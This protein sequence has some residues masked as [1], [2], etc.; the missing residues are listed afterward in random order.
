M[1]TQATIDV[2]KVTD[3]AATRAI[4]DVI[5]STITI[6]NYTLNFQE[7]LNG[8]TAFGDWTVL[9]GTVSL[10]QNAGGTQNGFVFENTGA[11]IGRPIPITFAGGAVVTRFDV[12]SFQSEYGMGTS[13]D[14]DFEIKIYEGTSEAGTLVGTFAA[15]ALTDTPVTTNDVYMTIER[16]DTDADNRVMLQMFTREL[17]EPTF[18]FSD[19]VPTT[20]AG[21]T[22]TWTVD[23]GNATPTSGT[24][25]INLTG[26]TTPNIGA[27]SNVVI[28]VMD[29]VTAA[30]VYEN[31]ASATGTELSASQ[32]FNATGQAVT[33]GAAATSLVE[34]TGANN[35]H[36]KQ[37]NLTGIGHNIPATESTRFSIY[38]TEALALAGGNGDVLEMGTIVGDGTDPQTIENGTA[39]DTSPLV[40][41]TQYWYK[42]RHFDDI[43]PT[44]NVIGESGVCTFT[45]RAADDENFIVCFDEGPNPASRT[46]TLAA[47]RFGEDD[48]P[49]PGNVSVYI[50]WEVSLSP[51]GPWTLANLL[52]L[53]GNPEANPSYSP[54]ATGGL[55]RTFG[56]LDHNTVY[57]SR[58][59]IG[60]DG[61]TGD[62]ETVNC[63]PLAITDDRP[64]PVCTSASN[65]TETTATVSATAD[66]TENGGFG[67]Y[68]NGDTVNLYTS[69]TA[70]GPW[71][72][73]GT[74][75]VNLDPE[76]AIEASV[77][78]NLTGLTPD[79]DYFYAFEI[80]E[81]VESGG[82]FWDSR[83]DGCATPFHTL[84]P[85]VGDPSVTKT[86]VAPDPVTNPA[87][88]VSTVVVTMA[89]FGGSVDVSDP[90]PAT[91]AGTTRSWTST[92]DAT[93]SAGAGTG[94]I[95]ETLVFA[96]AGTHTYTITDTVT[97]GGD[98]QNT[99]SIDGGPDVTGGDP[100]PVPDP[101]PPVGD[102]PTEEP[103]GNAKCKNSVSL[104]SQVNITQMCNTA[105][106]DPVPVLLVTVASS[107][108]DVIP[109]D[110]T[111]FPAEAGTDA[112]G[113]MGFMRSYYTD[114]NG[115]YLQPQ[116]TQVGIC[117]PTPQV[118][119][120]IAFAPLGCVT[121]AAGEV[122]G[123]VFTA[124]TAA[125]EDGG[126][127]TYRMISISTDGTVT[128][129]YTGEWSNCPTDQGIRATETAVV[130]CANGQTVIE[131]RT[132]YFDAD[133]G[134]FIA[135][136]KGWDDGTGVVLV[137]P[138][139]FAYGEC[140][141]AAIDDVEHTETVESGCVSGV[142]WT[143]VTTKTYT[144]GVL[145]DTTVVYRDQAGTDQAAQ[146][147]LWTL[148]AC[149]YIADDTVD[150][151][152]VTEICIENP[153][154]TFSNAYSR[155]V[156]RRTVSGLGVVSIVSST[157][158]SVDGVN[159]SVTVPTG[160][161]AV[162]VCPINASTRSTNQ[163]TEA[164][165]ADGVPYSRITS[166]VYNDG[167]LE[168]SNTV[169][170]DS[171]E[172]VSVVTPTNFTLGACPVDDAAI[173]EIEYTSSIPACVENPAGNFTQW[174][175][176]QRET[177]DWLNGGVTL[178]DVA[179]EWSSDGVT[180]TPTAPAGT[181]TMGQ[182]S[183]DIDQGIRSRMTSVIGC[184][185]GVPYERR[186]VQSYD[187]NTGLATAAGQDFYV[188][189]A[190]TIVI[191]PP[192]NFR[193]GEC[194]ADASTYTTTVQDVAAT[195]TIA[196]A[197]DLISW[198]VRNR[199]S[200]T[201]TIQV[202]SGAVL[203]MDAGETISSGD[204]EEEGGTLSDTVA[205]VAG[206]GIFRVTV[207]RR[208]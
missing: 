113:I 48:F 9:N 177:F 81:T 97:E 104:C 77:P 13:A 23:S 174:Y 11:K 146:P 169:Y 196:P 114:T 64:N 80:S 121:N 37:V 184:A 142:D 145:T 133:D 68:Q 100:V 162:G 112:F 98:Y 197:T 76:V 195:L 135:E 190:G 155:T 166:S 144:A 65:I 157:E 152:G 38:S 105:G 96:D 1:V 204:I 10:G 116:P 208:D 39:H 178:Q 54:N 125:D 175:V 128:D 74:E 12:V 207:M 136:V 69:L 33:V 73:A 103:W 18:D 141:V 84:A 58:A 28:T 187:A 57:Y 59:T 138:A 129:P 36:S 164:G 206:N 72:L 87:V 203:V 126:A 91:P 111:E 2:D 149:E 43:T 117:N 156:R 205:L 89:N 56:G 34:C 189:S 198:T 183:V 90:I 148:G 165:C 63:G 130:G 22:R 92:G 83:P 134:Q 150:Y 110:S 171:D 201:G 7:N 53:S 99:V 95:T 30:G 180:W 202:N 153:A 44:A 170:V 123:K 31:T 101:E 29:T 132:A 127:V 106:A 160:T 120:E 186:H 200:T 193:L 88:F 122:T 49:G 42:L 137:Q 51:T 24:G 14:G 6:S 67:S 168:S 16:I 8:P 107:D 173:H 140:V 20:P 3:G 82:S 199:S 79:T 163:V 194:V 52:D 139:G 46:A 172:V 115:V 21:T 158:Y 85:P 108:G 94:D 86:T 70:G 188:N 182:C 93:G 17:N 5:T 78:F 75:T 102:P 40:A 60:R 50:R 176:R 151:G 179:N 109:T 191:A 15:N 26:L 181:I 147:A 62:I 19:P 25:D 71:T 192:V 61:A 41:S 161:I 131:R 118:G 4:G 27:N 45:T 35:I 55:S 185:D 154:N 124:E 66:D 159:W 32:P 47:I 167:V 143:R 119:I